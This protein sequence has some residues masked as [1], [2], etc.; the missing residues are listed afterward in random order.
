MI[1]NAILSFYIMI[2]ELL[3]IMAGALL[4]Q[5]VVYWLT[6]FSIYNFINKFLY[7]EL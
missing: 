1:I 4:L 3:G 6:G 7:K 2:L 5:G